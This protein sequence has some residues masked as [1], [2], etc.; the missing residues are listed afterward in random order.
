MAN[1]EIL[2]RINKGTNE[3]VRPAHTTLIDQ[4]GVN[5]AG[6]FF[7]VTAL[8]DTQIDV[9]QCDTGIYEKDGVTP[10]DTL[11]PVA[12]LDITIP[13]GMTVYSNIETLEIIGGT[14]LA[15]SGPGDKPSIS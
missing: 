14:L 12:S 4:P 7:A 11:V 2:K 5:Y 9:S 1:E 6:P 3:A 10:S 15:Y 8:R 13:A